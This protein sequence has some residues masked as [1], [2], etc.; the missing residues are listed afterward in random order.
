VDEISDGGIRLEF[1]SG[2]ASV[3]DLAE[4][5]GTLHRIGFR[6][7]PIDLSTAPNAI[8]DLL[9]RP[10]LEE[11]DVAAVQQHF[12]LSRQR[13]V[14][15]IGEAGR[16]PQVSGGGEMSTFDATNG[17]TYPQLYIIGP[18]VDYTRFDHF[19]VNG[20]SDGGGLDEVMQVLSGGGIKVLQ[21]LPGEGVFTVTIDGAPKER[22]WIVTYDGG[23]PHIGSFSDA[24]A[25]TKVLVQAIGPAS[26]QVRYVDSPEV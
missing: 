22:G 21:H 14:E 3:T 12:L 23:R 24:T 7:W 18:G 19:H 26:W 2:R 15:L 5:N 13:L 20:T 10:A 25:G 11:T 9:A 16:S 4:I 6:A 1:A 8:Q 17:V